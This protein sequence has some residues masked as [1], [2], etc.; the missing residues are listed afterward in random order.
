LTYSGLDENPVLGLD[1]GLETAFKLFDS[2]YLN[3]GVISTI[4][5]N[6]GNIAQIYSGF[7]YKIQFRKKE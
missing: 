2:L 5:K 6:T 3:F 4:N 7:S 1:I